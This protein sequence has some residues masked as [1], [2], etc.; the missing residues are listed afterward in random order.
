MKVRCCQEAI[1]RQY[2]K[3]PS[4]L[5]E[6]ITDSFYRHRHQNSSDKTFVNE[7]NLGQSLLQFLTAFSPLFSLGAQVISSRLCTWKF[8][9]WV[10][11]TDLIVS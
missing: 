8:E 2:L 10:L 3:Y 4:A 11:T 5:Q 9:I 7:P 1:R 6:E